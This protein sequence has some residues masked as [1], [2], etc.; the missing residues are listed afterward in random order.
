MRKTSIF[1]FILFLFHSF[2]SVSVAHSYSNPFH[3]IFDESSHFAYVKFAQVWLQQMDF[4]KELVFGIFKELNWSLDF[5]DDF[6]FMLNLFFVSLMQ[7][8]F[9]IKHIFKFLDIIIF[10]LEDATYEWVSFMMVFHVS[11]VL[12]EGGNNQARP[13]I[14]YPNQFWTLL[15]GRY[16]LIGVATVI[17]I[18]D[19]DVRIWWSG[20]S[21]RTAVHCLLLKLH[22]DLSL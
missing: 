15:R 13:G 9:E 17:K 14:E 12:F 8:E 21:V 6:L 20:G 16:I 10:Q 1:S 18:L 19:K 2:L 3:L 22:N 11:E 5:D 4:C 7:F